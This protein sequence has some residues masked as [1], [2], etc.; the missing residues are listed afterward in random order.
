MDIV[1]QRACGRLDASD[2]VWL[3]VSI[4]ACQPD[5]SDVRRP[6]TPLT[7]ILT[8]LLLVSASVQLLLHLRLQLRDLLAALTPPPG[9][10]ASPRG[11]R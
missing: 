1:L 4:S 10:G 6:P 2:I 5:A 8:L 7:L 11:E 3:L 9:R